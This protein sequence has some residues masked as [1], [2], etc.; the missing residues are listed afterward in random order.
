MAPPGICW[1]HLASVN[2]HFSSKNKASEAVLLSPLLPPSRAEFEPGSSEPGL[3]QE[4]D[5]DSTGAARLG[6]SSL[7]APCAEGPTAQQALGLPGWGDP[8]SRGGR[9][10][11]RSQQTLAPEAPGAMEHS[12]AR[13]DQFMP[14]A[15]TRPSS[16]EPALQGCATPPGGLPWATGQVRPR[17]QRAQKAWEVPVPLASLGPGSLATLRPDSEARLS[18]QGRPA[19]GI[20]WK[21]TEITPVGV[22]AGAGAKSNLPSITLASW[23]GPPVTNGRSGK[24]QF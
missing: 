3:Q 21:R 6:A 24:E 7:W 19:V 14:P 22:G 8:D 2:Q 20:R 17:A 18:L 11:G 13:R 15:S 1:H 12:G 5:T 16:G 9:S 4:A 23:R 10:Q